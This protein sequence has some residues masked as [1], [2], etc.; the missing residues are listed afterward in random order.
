MMKNTVSVPVDGDPR[1]TW[2]SPA[3]LA[4]H[5][6]DS[7]IMILDCRRDVHDYFRGHI[8]GAHHVPECLFR[9]HTGTFP[10]QWMPPVVAEDVIRSLG[11]HDGHTVVV[12]TDGTTAL[13]TSGTSASGDGLE[14][15]FVAYS[16][17]R[18]GHAR[19]YILDG[20]RTKWVKENRLQDQTFPTTR[21]SGFTVTVQ[22]D[23]F[24]GYPELRR[25][26]DQ[27]GVVL[28]DTRP[29]SAYAGQASW[30]RPGHIP[31]AVNIPAQLLMDEKNSALLKSRE[32]IQQIFLAQGISPDKT[33]ICSCGTG[34][35]ATSVFL[36]LKYFLDYPRVLIFEGGFTEWSTYPDNPLVT[37]KNPG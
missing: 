32:E 23:F 11:I 21:Q 31:G 37:G 15:A 28:L 18:Y 25:I 34:R 26:K 30:I 13:G 9:M 16:L 6:D 17:V 5:R 35:T 4:D 33:I 19:V 3:W 8:T 2:V 1:V 10:M 36:I 27:P 12:Y 24:I 22:Q 7:S 20:G 29:P 14:A